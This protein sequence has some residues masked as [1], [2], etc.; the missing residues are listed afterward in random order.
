MTLVPDLPW[1]HDL[2]SHA[3]IAQ[4]LQQQQKQKR[5][6][7]DAYSAYDC[8]EEHKHRVTETMHSGALLRQRRLQIALQQGAGH[9]AR[10]NLQ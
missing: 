3:F 9:P 1:P 10:G 5:I 6:N 2:F 8:L 4:P 7:C